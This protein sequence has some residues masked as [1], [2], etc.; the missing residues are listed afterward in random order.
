LEEVKDV[1]FIKVL[2]FAFVS[3]VEETVIFI[4]NYG[5]VH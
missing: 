1:A 4:L 5:V 2:I 3:F